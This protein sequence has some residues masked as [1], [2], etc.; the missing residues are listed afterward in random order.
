[1]QLHIIYIINYNN[2]HVY[3]DRWM[4]KIN[5]SLT[6]FYHFH[7]IV[8]HWYEEKV[9]DRHPAYQML[10]QTQVALRGELDETRMT[11]R[12][13]LFCI[14]NFEK[15]KN[16]MEKCYPLRRSANVNRF[17]SDPILICRGM[18]LTT[19]G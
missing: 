15:T 2:T 7:R 18:G 8:L 19:R 17:L 11:K 6:N 14:Q 10:Y 12:K 9:C 3:T 4:D 13:V 16:N 5:G 1:M